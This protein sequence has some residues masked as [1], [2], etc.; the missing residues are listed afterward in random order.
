MKFIDR[1]INN[2]ES[3][4]GQLATRDLVGHVLEL[5]LARGP[6][7]LVEH[8]KVEFFAFIELIF[9]QPWVHAID[10]LQEQI[11]LIFGQ[12]KLEQINMHNPATHTHI[13]FLNE[14]SLAQLTH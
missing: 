2:P 9:P 1:I 3:T 11:W 10:R 4:L 7:P 5:V 13:H 12:V 8:Q 14:G 6:R